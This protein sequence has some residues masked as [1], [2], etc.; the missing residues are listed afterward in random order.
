MRRIQPTYCWWIGR[1]GWISTICETKR[2]IP[3]HLRPKIEAARRFT[4]ILKGGGGVKYSKVGLK[5]AQFFLWKVYEKDASST[6]VRV[7]RGPGTFSSWT[8]SSTPVFWYRREQFPGGIASLSLFFSS[9]I[10]HCRCSQTLRKLSYT[11]EEFILAADL[12]LR[13]KRDKV[14][15]FCVLSGSHV[16]WVNAVQNYKTFENRWTL[17]WSLPV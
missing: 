7:S 13:L 10:L 2:S 4:F 17:K 11:R 14:S 12:S 16:C 9:N 15:Y 1:C 6:V 5:E 3:S 8:S